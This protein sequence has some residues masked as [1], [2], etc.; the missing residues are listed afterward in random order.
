MEDMYAVSRQLVDNQ[1]MLSAPTAAKDAY[2]P[3]MHTNAI[4]T[5]E[6]RRK[7]LDLEKQEVK[8]RVEEVALKKQKL[9]PDKLEL[10]QRRSQQTKKMK[11]AV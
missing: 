11:V 6:N 3:T 4:L 9:H 5:A 10:E 8:A 7:R 2:F 1:F